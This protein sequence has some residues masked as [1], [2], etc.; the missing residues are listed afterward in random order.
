MTE[1]LSHIA[2][3]KIN[4]NDVSDIR[5]PLKINCL[6]ITFLKRIV[7]VD[8]IPLT[9]TGKVNRLAVKELIS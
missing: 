6:I 3:R 1:T 2:L 4:G 9:E 8:S 7:K 5:L